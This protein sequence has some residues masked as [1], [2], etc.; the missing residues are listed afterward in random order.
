MD[1]GLR[2]GRDQVQAFKAHIRWWENPVSV[3]ECL[4]DLQKKETEQQKTTDKQS[5]VSR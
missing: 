5:C 3:K 2:R 4:K 1:R